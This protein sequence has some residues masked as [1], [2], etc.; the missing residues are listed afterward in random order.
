MGFILGLMHSPTHKTDYYPSTGHFNRIL[1]TTMVFI[2]AAGP[3]G[4]YEKYGARSAILCQNWGDF[5]QYLTEL[6]SVYGMS[7]NINNVFVV[8]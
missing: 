6:C 3:R 2:I 5:D 4:E 1:V 8:G 7:D